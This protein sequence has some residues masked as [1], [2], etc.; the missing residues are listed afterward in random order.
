MLKRAVLTLL[1]LLAISGA[2]VAAILYSGACVGETGQQ[3]T[4]AYKYPQETNSK[5][6]RVF[7]TV[8]LLL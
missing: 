6:Q 3:D 4:D 2:I 1:A 5:Y 7:T 8:E